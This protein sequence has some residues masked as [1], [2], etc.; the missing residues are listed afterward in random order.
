MA[1]FKLL[2][3]LDPREE[4]CSRTFYSMRNITGLIHD[5]LVRNYDYDKRWTIQTSLDPCIG[6]K[7][8]IA[9]IE[10]GGMK[11]SIYFSNPPKTPVLMPFEE[12]KENFVSKP[13]ISKK[14]S[15]TNLMCSTDRANKT[16]L[17]QHFYN[18]LESHDYCGN[19]SL[20]VVCAERLIHVIED[21]TTELSGNSNTDIAFISPCD[22]DPF[23]PIFMGPEDGQE[24][25]YPSGDKFDEED[26]L[27]WL[28]IL[29]EKMS[30]L[31]SKNT[32][33]KSLPYFVL[34]F[35]ILVIICI[36]TC[37]RNYRHE[38]GYSAL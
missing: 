11:L 37:V 26:P 17:P 22:G 6:K 3:I 38:D 10:I 23:L 4:N 13:G 12:I 25:E 5:D 19:R 31:N 15:S 8:N 24:E 2:D 30:N 21:N 36:F 33:T 20:C 7:A 9:E 16:Y 32:V 28:V 35:I 14:K 34:L 29:Q 27:E 1:T 18:K